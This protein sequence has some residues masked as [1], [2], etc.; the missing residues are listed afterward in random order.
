MAL[1]TAIEP[2]AKPLHVLLH[3]LMLHLLQTGHL[4]RKSLRLVLHHDLAILDLVQQVTGAGFCPLHRHARACL[5]DC[6]K[7][8][9]SP[10]L[11]LPSSGLEQLGL[12]GCGRRTS[13][14]AN[15]AALKRRGARQS[16]DGRHPRGH[17]LLR[18]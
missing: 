10:L 14:A 8:R 3:L 11:A 17:H 13:A 5:H 2:I 9:G 7:V 16:R 4:D 18:L 6:V 15:T 1:V 12:V